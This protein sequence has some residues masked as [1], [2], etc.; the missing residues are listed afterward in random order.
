M[1]GFACFRILDSELRGLNNYNSG[2]IFFGNYCDRCQKKRATLV[3]NQL[4]VDDPE[5]LGVAA[6]DDYARYDKSG[7][8]EEGLG[9]PSV[10][11]LYDRAG[12]QVRVVIEFAWK[13]GR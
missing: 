1:V 4:P 5:Y 13:N 10:R 8:E 6:N 3:Y 11:V 9:T 2:I 12:L 7:D